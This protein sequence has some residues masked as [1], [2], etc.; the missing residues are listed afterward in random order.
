MIS[1][2]TF[3]GQ[4]QQ[5]HKAKNDHVMQ[6]TFLQI[7]YGNQ[8]HQTRSRGDV[9]HWAALAICQHKCVHSRRNGTPRRCMAAVQGQQAS[10]NQATWSIC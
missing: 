1:F 10:S 6:F 8:L 7:I 9:L 3:F 5:R 4:K 2:L